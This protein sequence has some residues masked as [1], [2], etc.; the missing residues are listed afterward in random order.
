VYNTESVVLASVVRLYCSWQTKV[1]TG[2]YVYL[3]KGVIRE[4]NA[5]SNA[6]P[7]DVLTR[8]C[9]IYGEIIYA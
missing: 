3:N 6:I 2:H 9:Q 5:G 8:Y 4:R 7:K 1:I